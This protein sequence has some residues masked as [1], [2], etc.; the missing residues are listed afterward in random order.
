MQKNHRLFL[1]TLSQHISHRALPER[2]FKNDDRKREDPHRASETAAQR[3]ARLVERPEFSAY[4]H[5][6]HT[7]HCLIERLRKYQITSQIAIVRDNLLK[8]YICE[9]R[10]ENSE[11]LYSKTVEQME[12]IATVISTI[13]LRGYYLFHR[14]IF[15]GHYSRAAT[16]RGRRLLD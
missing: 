5:C 16:N 1:P 11:T 3:E 4:M 12:A 8:F 14:A 7:E 9:R 10:R 15:R 6:Q 2:N 13:R